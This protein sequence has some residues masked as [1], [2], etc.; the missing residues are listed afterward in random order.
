MPEAQVDGVK[1]AA[2]LP[3]PERAGARRAAPGSVSA[4]GSGGRRRNG[5]HSYQR[6]QGSWDV[7]ASG[8]RG[9]HTERE[10]EPGMHTCRELF[11]G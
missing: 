4:S 7:Q 6:P 2:L 10:T 11:T 1:S 5:E 9:G 3:K 8:N